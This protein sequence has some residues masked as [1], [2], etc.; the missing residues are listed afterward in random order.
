MLLDNSIRTFSLPQLWRDSHHRNRKL[1]CLLSPD[2]RA[3]GR[4]GRRATRAGSQ[5]QWR[6][7]Q[8]RTAESGFWGGSFPWQLRPE[9]VDAAEGASYRSTALESA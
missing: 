7:E 6:G 1:R 9:I 2:R 8:C 3:S 4:N 5:G